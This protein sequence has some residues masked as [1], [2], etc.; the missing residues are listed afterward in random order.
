MLDIASDGVANQIR[1]AVGLQR[2]L[3]KN[4]AR[5]SVDAKEPAVRIEREDA[6]G[7]VLEH[8]LDQD[9]ASIQLLHGA[10]QML[11]ELVDLLAAIRRAKSEARVGPRSPVERVTVSGPPERLNALR[12]VE[13]DIRAAQNVGQ[14]VLIVAAEGEPA[15]VEV[16]LAGS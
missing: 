10:L 3:A 2:A 4:L 9:A 13:D 16:K 8:R 11:S 7:N 14:L 1:Q 5:R 12:L 6:S 15:A